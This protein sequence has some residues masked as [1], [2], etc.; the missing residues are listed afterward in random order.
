MRIRCLRVSGAS[1][2]KEVGFA[3]LEESAAASRLAG[4]DDDTGSPVVV[5]VSE[6]DDLTTVVTYDKEFYDRQVRK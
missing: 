3:L 4:N 6:R 1:R 2:L 5:T